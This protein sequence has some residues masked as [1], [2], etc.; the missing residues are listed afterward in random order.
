[1]PSRVGRISRVVKISLSGRVPEP[2]TDCC[3]RFDS[4]TKTAI[5]SARI[6]GDA[7][8]ARVHR[9]ESGRTG[10]QATRVLMSR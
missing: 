5:S 7:Q 6:A 4:G 3:H 10:K 9:H 1:M 2:R 8:T